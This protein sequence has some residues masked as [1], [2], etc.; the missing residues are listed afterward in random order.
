[1][2]TFITLTQAGGGEIVVNVDWIAWITPHP[3]EEGT[4]IYLGVGRQYSD[5]TS[6]SP[7]LVWVEQNHAAIRETL[8]DAVEM[9]EIAK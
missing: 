4:L 8:G 2:A 7:A 5:G 6:Q 3:K 1:M 9:L